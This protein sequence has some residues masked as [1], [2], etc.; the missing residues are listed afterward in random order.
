M[1]IGSAT[2]QHLKR[3]P[4]DQRPLAVRVNFINFTIQIQAY[5]ED[6]YS[7]NLHAIGISTGCAKH[8]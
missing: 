3:L 6:F 2:F 1:P 5:E 4:A 7:R 8:F